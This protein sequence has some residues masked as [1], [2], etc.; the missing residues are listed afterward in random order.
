[1][2]YFDSQKLHYQIICYPNSHW[3]KIIQDTKN[4]Q[5]KHNK[6]NILLHKWRKWTTVLQ[7]NEKKK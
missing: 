1:M 2:Q 3:T 6:Q 7:L 4:E 5:D